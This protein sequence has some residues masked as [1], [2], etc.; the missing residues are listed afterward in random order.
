M[1][2]EA[3]TT[4]DAVR[5]ACSAPDKA[6]CA[7]VSPALAA[8]RVFSNW[9]RASAYF[10]SGVSVDWAP[11]TMLAFRPFK[12]VT[13]DLDFS[14]ADLAA[15]DSVSYALFFLNDAATT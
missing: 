13:Q 12:V 15:A 2:S 10:C 8:A 1:A 11:R 3:L 5:K 14:S 4:C 7:V 9:A 6:D